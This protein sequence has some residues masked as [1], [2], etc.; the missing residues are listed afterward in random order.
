MVYARQ[1][2]T[3]NNFEIILKEIQILE[4]CFKRYQLHLT[5]IID[6]LNVERFTK[7]KIFLIT[8]KAISAL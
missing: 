8:L 7:I 5:L 3:E 1:V 4:Q 6:T 2:S